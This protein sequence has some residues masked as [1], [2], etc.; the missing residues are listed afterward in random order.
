ME[1]HEPQNKIYISNAFRKVSLYYYFH[2]ETLALLLRWHHSFFNTNMILCLNRH[3]TKKLAAERQRKPFTGLICSYSWY[4]MQKYMTSQKHSVLQ[5]RKRG[6][7][8]NAYINNNSEMILEVKHTSS[9]TKTV[10][11]HVLNRGQQRGQHC[12]MTNRNLRNTG[13]NKMSSNEDSS[14]VL[15]F[16]RHSHFIRQSM[17]L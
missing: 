12:K 11:V 6:C 8:T 14:L 15:P 7:Q 2:H 17:V 9:R 1:K 3:R 10:L 5:V 16:N 4:R 13:V